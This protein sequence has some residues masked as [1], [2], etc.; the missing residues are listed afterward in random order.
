M[1]KLYSVAMKLGEKMGAEF[2]AFKAQS[3]NISA[4]TLAA[5]RAFKDLPESK[6][7]AYLSK[8]L[9]DMNNDK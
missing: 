3:N 5:I 6:Q 4:E 7:E 2:L 1:K 9:F 8:V